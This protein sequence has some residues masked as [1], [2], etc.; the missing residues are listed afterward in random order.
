[1]P[2]VKPLT[3]LGVSKAVI[4]PKSWLD[5]YERKTGHVITEVLMEINDAL[6]IR[7]VSKED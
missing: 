6:T 4:L 3:K 1:M 7:I 5:Y 2:I